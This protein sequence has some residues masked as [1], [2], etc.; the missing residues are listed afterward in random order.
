MEKKKKL[1]ARMD[2]L[3]VISEWMTRASKLVPQ[4]GEATA[5]VLAR[6][7]A[8]ASRELLNEAEAALNRPVS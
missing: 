6:A 7:L 5:V 1:Q 2:T 3:Q 8:M 4:E